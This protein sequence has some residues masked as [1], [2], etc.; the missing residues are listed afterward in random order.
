MQFETTYSKLKNGV[1][2]LAVPIKGAES[3]TA[4]VLVKTG[5]RNESDK[6]AGISHVL[7]HMLFKGTK[8]Y[9]T[10]LALAEAVDAM[11]ALNNAFTG[12]EYT[13]YYITA[14]G[15][16][17]PKSLEILGEMLTSP[18][19]PAEDLKRERE[20]IVEEINMYEDHPMERAGEEFENLIYGGSRMGKL[21][22]GT[23]ESVRATET[24]DLRRYMK[25]WYR[26]G[27]VL[28]VVAGKVANGLEHT[29]NS[30]IE[31]HF[32]GLQKGAKLDYLESAGYGKEKEFHLK[33]KTEQAHFVIG[34][35]GLS[36]LDPR[37]YALQIA[38]IVLG[39]NMSSRLFNEIREKR[40]LAYYVGAEVETNYDVG[41]LAVKAGVRL[42]KLTEAMAVVQQEMLELGETITEKEVASAKDYLLGKLPLS[43]EGSMEVAR[44]L[45]MRAL[46]TEE[47][48]QPEEVKERIK[49]VTKVEVQKVL[50]EVM[51]D[52]KLRS[53]VVG[54]R[55][56]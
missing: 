31:E 1:R 7:E 19:I 47:I 33:K 41:Y 52:E 46:V 54:P 49:K 3:V 34:V 30:L 39:G 51:S 14:S 38:E 12:K 9:P 5:S 50:R 27:N 37:R 22:I 16:H 53:V 28:V 44:F 48:R 2:V 45:G 15:K 8:K 40:G 29:A 42:T 13:G 35:P 20:V 21:I 56:G 17:L 55:S 10:A 36:M 4:L 32:G 18:L 6:Q 23:K 43:L 11:G 25:K 24:G 26:G